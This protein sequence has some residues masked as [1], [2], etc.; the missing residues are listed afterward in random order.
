MKLGYRI[1]S[2]YLFL[3]F[4]Q[5]NH[6]AESTFSKCPR[7]MQQVGTSSFDT[8]SQPQGA[9]FATALPRLMLKVSSQSFTDGK[10]R[11]VQHFGTMFFLKQ[12]TDKEIAKHSLYGSC[13]YKCF[14]FAWFLL[15]SIVRFWLC[16]GC[17]DSVVN[18]SLCFMF[19][20][21]LFGKEGWGV[22]TI[23]NVRFHCKIN[24][25]SCVG[26][27]DFPPPFF[28]YWPEMEKCH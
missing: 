23:R 7:E 10:L 28:Q 5:C 26:L 22:T 1:C 27:F 17:H 6:F 20:L 12:M 3:F 4:S 11:I 18:N 21:Q 2:F 8:T 14:S 19:F 25:A 15:Q 13:K 24:I 16:L 9:C